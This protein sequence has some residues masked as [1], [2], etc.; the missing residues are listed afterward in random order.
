MAAY[1]TKQYEVKPVSI[2]GEEGAYIV[3][4][5]AV[6]THNKISNTHGFVLYST[7]NIGKWD[8]RE[9]APLVDALFFASEAEAFSLG[10]IIIR[11]NLQVAAV[12][13]YNR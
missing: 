2:I 11:M 7:T 6:Y 8:V 4:L 10:E 13:R 12:Q 1:A 3:Y 5:V 9:E